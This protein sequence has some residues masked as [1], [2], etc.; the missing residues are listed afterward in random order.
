MGARG[1]RPSSS[2]SP[3]LK[4]VDSFNGL[5]LSADRGAEDIAPLADLLVV[6]AVD[7]LVFPKG[8]R[9]G[10]G[11]R[12]GV[13]VVRLG[14]DGEKGEAFAVAAIDLDF[15]RVGI[16][17]V[18]E[19]GGAARLH[20]DVEL[21]LPCGRV[22]DLVGTDDAEVLPDGVG[23][24]FVLFDAGDERGEPD[25]DAGRDRRRDGRGQRGCGGQVG[26]GGAA[27]AQQVF[28]GSPELGVLP[29]LVEHVQ[30]VAEGGCVGL[31]GGEVGGAHFERGGVFGKL[32]G[33]VIEQSGLAVVVFGCE[34][35]FGHGSELRIMNY[36]LRVTDGLVL[37]GC[38][39]GE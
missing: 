18:P 1:D 14:V 8:A 26:A 15:Q 23:V 3:R 25:K 38:F 20:L 9:A 16:A 35:S 33:E 13:G 31:R 6:Q 39:S 36:E 4:S 5:L 22:D 27:V 10:G 2:F 12:G 28:V 24:V 7:G 37:G 11:Q 29:H 32:R 17:F 30:C 19:N 21:R 34:W